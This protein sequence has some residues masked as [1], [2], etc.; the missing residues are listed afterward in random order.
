MSNLLFRVGSIVTIADKSTKVLIIGQCPED[1]EKNMF[2]YA[3]VQYPEGLVNGNYVL[4]NH[5]DIVVVDEEK[6]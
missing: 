1:G 4:F 3:G 6:R 5:R 2:D